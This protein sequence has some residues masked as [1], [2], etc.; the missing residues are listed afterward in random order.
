LRLV[1]NNKAVAHNFD[2]KHMS[3]VYGYQ[4]KHLLRTPIRDALLELHFIGFLC[5]NH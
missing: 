1:D 4:L 3:F 5:E 2:I